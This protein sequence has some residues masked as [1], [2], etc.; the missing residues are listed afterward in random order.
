MAELPKQIYED[1]NATHLPINANNN[2][3]VNTMPMNEP[4][5]ELKIAAA[6]FPPADLVRIT[7]DD[8]GGGIHDTT[9][10]PPIK[11]VSSDVIDERMRVRK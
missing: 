8:T 5:A 10:M 11:Y 9:V 7:A 1:S 3:G 4:K 2:I 6:S